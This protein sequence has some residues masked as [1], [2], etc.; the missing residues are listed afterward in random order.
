M[1]A[2][3]RW[4]TEECDIVM[5][6]DTGKRELFSQAFREAAIDAMDSAQKLQAVSCW[7]SIPGLTTSSKTPGWKWS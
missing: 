2:R 7:L 1:P 4:E 6:D 3:L 5:V